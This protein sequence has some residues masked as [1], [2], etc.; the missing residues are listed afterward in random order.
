MSNPEIDLGKVFNDPGGVR[1]DEGQRLG[2][3]KGVL[4][5]LAIIA[6]GAM[7]AHGHWPDN[8]GFADSFELIKI[9]ALP[10][11]TLVI[12]FYFPKSHS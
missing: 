6:T 11:V 2:L 4:I 5:V 1:L 9:G 3:A 8:K 7:V 10:L 12:S